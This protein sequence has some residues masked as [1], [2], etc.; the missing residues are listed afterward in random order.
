VSGR[1]RLTAL[2]V[3]VGSILTSTNSPA[4]AAQNGRHI[5]VQFNLRGYL[6]GAGWNSTIAASTFASINARNPKPLVTSLNEVCWEQWDDIQSNAL[7]DSAGWVAFAHWSIDERLPDPL[8][9]VCDDPDGFADEIR[10]S[11]MSLSAC[12]ALAQLVIT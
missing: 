10:G 9:E 5:A 2:L 1:L 8:D 3:I 11:E 12:G 6:S 4:S 7:P